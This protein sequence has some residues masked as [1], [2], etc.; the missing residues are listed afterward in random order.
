MKSLKIIAATDKNNII[1][2]D[3]KIPWNFTSEMDHFKAFTMN[4]TVIMGFNTFDSLSYPL[5]NRVNVVVTSDINKIKNKIKSYKQPPSNLPIILH[6]KTLDEFF[7]SDLS[8]LG[9]DLICIGG[10]ATYN[11]VLPFAD[12]IVL[13]VLDYNLLSEF[14]LL[15]VTSDIS[16]IGTDKNGDTHSISFFPK[17]PKG[18]KCFNEKDLY[19]DSLKIGNILYYKNTLIP[20]NVYDIKTKTFLSIEKRYELL[21]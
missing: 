9:D 16:G 3:G 14:S 19:S 7:N 18:Y 13:T 11:S 8:E 5:K 10:S 21:K 6:A 2:V 15:E 1:G 12:E 20:N 4:K 17:I